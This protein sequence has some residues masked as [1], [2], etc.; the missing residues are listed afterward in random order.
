ML[1]IPGVYFTGDLATKDKDGYFWIQGRTDDVLSIT[2]HR[3]G[4]AE[5][6]SA[7][8]THEAVVEAGVIGVPDE[9]KGETAKAF[10][11]LKQGYEPSAPPNPLKGS[12]GYRMRTNFRV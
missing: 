5:V 7:F 8:V 6:E 3:I 4:T 12:F 11:I 2:G 10:V 1:K 9:I